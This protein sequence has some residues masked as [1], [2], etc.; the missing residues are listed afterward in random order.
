MASLRSLYRTCF[1]ASFAL[2]ASSAGCNR[3]SAVANDSAA[4]PLASA[5][6]V[7]SASPSAAP[8]G[9][10]LSRLIPPARPGPRSPCPLTVEPGVA[11]GPVLL[12][13]TVA[14]LE[15]AGLTVKKVS[16]THAEVSLAG[17]G[18]VGGTDAVLK[19]TLCQGKI[20][21]VWV[22]DLRL[23]PTCVAYAGKSVAPS[24]PREELEK[25]LG[26]CTDAP[27]RIGGTFESCQGGGVYVGHGMGTFLQVRVRPKAFPFDDACSVASDDGS[28]VTLAPSDRDA[29]VRDTLMLR[30]LGPYWHV[31]EPGRDPLRIVRTALVPEQTLTM[32]GSPVVWI[33]ESAATKGTAFL[34]IT[35]LAA[36]RTKATLSF[37]YPI[38]G[39][40]GTA[41]FSRSGGS[42]TYRL[43]RGEVRER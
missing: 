29:M 4:T 16:D 17:T 33:D 14:D 5:A 10:M 40:V 22:D 31:D 38:E 27:P 13:E 3:S 6:P 25:L 2:I 11:F 19:I 8:S 36:T 26:G 39:V 20:I 32:F 1:V 24:I 35:A 42:S 21:D 9:A 41:T 12:G 18:A 34:R 30:E 28:P 43:A 37:E 7:A 15:S 23:A